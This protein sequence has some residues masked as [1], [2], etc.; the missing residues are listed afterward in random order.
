MWLM[1]YKWS[2]RIAANA[3]TDYGIHCLNYSKEDV[4]KLLREEAFQERSEYEDKYQRATLSQVGLCTYFT[5]ATEILSFR[6]EYKKKMGTNFK[7]KNF[8]EQFLGCGT[9][10]VKL[11]REL[12]L[13]KVR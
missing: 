5:G 3:I 4:T 7:L 6:E 1:Y 11:I 10:P 12:M 8:H 9:A 13:S 2:L